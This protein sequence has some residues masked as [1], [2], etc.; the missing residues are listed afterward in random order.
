[1]AG[2]GTMAQREIPEGLRER[3]R[4]VARVLLAIVAALALAA[5]AVGIRW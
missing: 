4:R 1:M 5:L 2:P 3:N